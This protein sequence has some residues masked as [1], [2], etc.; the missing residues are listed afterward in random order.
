M[1]KM[2]EEDMIVPVYNQIDHIIIPKNLIT[3]TNYLTNARSYPQ[4]D[5]HSDHR[6][7]V[8]TLKL[9]AIY[10]RSKVTKNEGPSLDMSALA[11]DEE[12]RSNYQLEISVP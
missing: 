4:G 5:Y 10:W 12:I 6:I 7:V 3:L 2:D 8:T 9:E 11:T 1:K